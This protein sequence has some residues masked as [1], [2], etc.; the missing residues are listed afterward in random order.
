MST[1][2]IN[3]G[4]ARWSIPTWYLFHGL[5]EKINID[6]FNRERLLVLKF[7]SVICNSLPCPICQQHASEYLKKEDFINK[8][9][10]KTD[11]INFFYTMH[12]WV[13]KRLKKKT[14]TKLEMELYKRINI[15]TCIKFWAQRFFQ[16]YY[17][18]NNFNN[19]R[20]H[21]IQQE[22]KK[23]FV[24]NYKTSMF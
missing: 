9:K 24:T 22:T 2:N 1:N 20:R 21:D 13:N 7:Y 3:S 12:N 11:L 5:A 10:T 15:I 14:F 6:F 16:Q 8:V 19:W 17:V 23:F 18:H 4:R